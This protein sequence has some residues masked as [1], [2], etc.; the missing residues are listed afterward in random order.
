MNI[1]A[2]HLLAQ[3]PRKP[4][5][6]FE[7]THK[8]VAFSQVEEKEKEIERKFTV[9]RFFS[10]LPVTEQMLVVVNTDIWDVAK[11]L[12]TVATAAGIGAGLG[13]LT[14]LSIKFLSREWIQITPY[15]TTIGSIL[16]A[17]VGYRISVNNFFKTHSIEISKS[18]KFI[19]WKNAIDKEK[20][21]LL[22]NCLK[23]HTEIDNKFIK[24]FCPLTL[25]IPVIPVVCPNGHVYEKEAIEAH[26][27][28]RWEAIQILKDSNYPQNRIDEALKT[29]S[30][31][32]AQ[33]FTKQDLK[34]AIDFS[35]EALDFFKAVRE[36]LQATKSPDEIV[37]EGLDL[38][39]QQ[40]QATYRA[41]TAET[42]SL[43]SVDIFRLGGTD[44][45]RRNIIR[46]YQNSMA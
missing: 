22:L 23:N 8:M 34:Y 17:R 40:Y 25:D 1:G 31:L 15:T 32:R 12:T 3:Y 43:M 42:I 24:F 30:P 18:I 6:E 10:Q 20:Y 28:L 39:L 33:P 35:K 44:E 14:G 38:L 21:D 7:S 37:M 36:H 4:L 29:I 13:A 26:L 16:G 19:E 2:E 46:Q 11:I 27:D 41:V 5:H 9:D 45:Q